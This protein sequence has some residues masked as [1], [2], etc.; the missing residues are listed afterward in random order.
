MHRTLIKVT[1]VVLSVSLVMAGVGTVLD[2]L[3]G[4]R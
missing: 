2:L 4:A 3:L 1:A